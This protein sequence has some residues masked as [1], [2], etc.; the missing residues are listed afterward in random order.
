MPASLRTPSVGQFNSSLQKKLLAEDIV[1][2]VTERKPKYSKLFYSEVY[3]A[4]DIK[5]ANIKY[6]INLSVIHKCNKSFGSDGFIILS[7]FTKVN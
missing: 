3:N 6:A 1:N 4:P 2:M 5:Y 7:M